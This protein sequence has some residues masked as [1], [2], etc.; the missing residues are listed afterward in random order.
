MM[1]LSVPYYEDFTRISSQPNKF[2]IRY[3]VEHLI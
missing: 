2:N 3:Y 1:D